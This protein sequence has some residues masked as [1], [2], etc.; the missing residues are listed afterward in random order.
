MIQMITLILLIIASVIYLI[1]IGSFIWW[2]YDRRYDGRTPISPNLIYKN[3]KIDKN[4]IINVALVSFDDRIKNVNDVYSKIRNNHR[5]YASTHDYI[6]YFGSEISVPNGWH[7]CWSKI[8]YLK[9]IVQRLKK[10]RVDYVMWIDS[11]AYIYDFDLDIRRIIKYH[12]FPDIV[13][14][15]DPPH[16]LG[17]QSCSGIMILSILQLENILNDILLCAE[18]FGGWFK[19]HATHEQFCLNVISSRYDTITLP[20]YVLNF[21]C[22]D[23]DI[24]YRKNNAEFC[25]FIIHCMGKASK[26]HLEVLN[27]RS[28]SRSRSA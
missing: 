7:T 6:H 5:R 25:P 9:S 24:Y 27:V 16:W 12:D 22:Y 20:Y 18:W 3:V 23:E 15:K 2:L 19:K 17:I 8:Y 21:T 26:R 11:D 4:P 14:S 1:I 10:R 28:R 13:V